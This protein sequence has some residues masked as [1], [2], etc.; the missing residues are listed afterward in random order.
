MGGK[1]TFYLIK[2]D[3]Q[4]LFLCCSKPSSTSST[5]TLKSLSSQ[6][7]YLAF[8]QKHKKTWSPVIPF[9][10]V[11]DSVASESFYSSSHADINL[12]CVIGVS[13]VL[14]VKTRQRAR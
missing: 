3:W 8:K 5:V 12:C 9:R 6:C 14:I 13:Y 4:F 1:L 10:T 11:P 7:S 2:P